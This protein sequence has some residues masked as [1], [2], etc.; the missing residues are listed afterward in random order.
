MDLSALND[1]LSSE[2]QEI[3][4]KIN[5][6]AS[7]LEQ[8]DE[9]PWTDVQAWTLRDQVPRHTIQVEVIDPLTQKSTIKVYTLWR[10]LTNEVTEL[11]GYPISFLAK[12]YL[13]LLASESQKDQSVKLEAPADILPFLDDFEF[14]SSGGLTGR[15]YGV[16]G[17][18]DGSRIET[19]PVGNVR[20]TVP[21]GFVTTEDGL[22]YELGI[23]MQA[24]ANADF[25]LDTVRR[26]AR[27]SSVRERG[28][29]AGPW[30]STSREIQEPGFSWDPD[31]VQFGALTTFVIGGALAFEA[32]QH[33]L[34]VNVFWV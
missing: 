20:A 27:R 11:S 32:L 18:A 7:H 25:A 22:L 15:A 33:H 28:R 13:A 19:T 5:G 34:T 9:Y 26:T 17:V 23:P 10:T 3:D 14:T 16:M 12:R 8:D 30:L 31:L 1:S 6:E 29:G 21:K 4:F 2:S 24:P